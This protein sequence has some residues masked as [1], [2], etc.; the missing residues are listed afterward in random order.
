MAAPQTFN[1]RVAKDPVRFDEFVPKFDKILSRGLCQGLGDR[2]GDSRMCIEAA[3]CT[4]L[5]TPAHDDH[6]PCVPEQIATFKIELNDQNWSSAEARAKGLRDLGIAQLGSKGIVRSR[7]FLSRVKK[8][9]VAD[10]TLDHLYFGDWTI[11]PYGRTDKDHRRVA[12][13]A[14]QVLTDLKSPGALWLRAE[15]RRKAKARKA[16]TNRG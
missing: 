15:K 10:P 12:A 2:R 16:R 4:V 5:G 9:I 13:I 3:I 8:A 7:S 11:V 6:P 1:G 14:V